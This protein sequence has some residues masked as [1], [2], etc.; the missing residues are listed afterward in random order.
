MQLI[1]SATLA[2]FATVIAIMLLKPLAFR[3][4]LVDL[5]GGRK[6]HVGKIPLVGGIGMFVGFCFAALLTPMPLAPYR[7][8]FAGSALMVL[9]GVL[10][11]FHEMS[12]RVKFILQIIAAMIMAKAG[13]VILFDLGNL[14]G[15]GAVHLS[16]LVACVV[17]VIATLG[18]MNAVN[19]TDGSDGLAASVSVIELSL[20]SYLA[21][22]QGLYSHVLLLSV[23]I[24]TLLGYLV[25][26]FPFSF[27]K[28]AAAFMGDAGSLFIGFM[29]AWFLISL[30]QAP[31]Q[32]AHPVVFL[33]IMAL[34]LFDATASIVRRLLKGGSPF[35][36]DAQHLH[37]L[38][39]HKN[40]SSLG[41][42]LIIGTSSFCMGA[43]GIFLGRLGMPQCSMFE[44]FIVCFVVYT[45]TVDIVWRNVRDKK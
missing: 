22:Q 11:D 28:K 19:M 36:P 13:G 39:K 31:F 12:A 32:V 43:L 34:P 21:Y 40:C 42:V 4:N 27:R 3:V 33:W 25:F 10:D 38:L 16:F 9:V 44:L 23:L 35:R 15:T 1:I 30:S 18:V 6:S 24:S 29:L 2:G 17:T 7:A 14:L 20:L 45:A 41:V 26:N 5:P 8:L 37:H